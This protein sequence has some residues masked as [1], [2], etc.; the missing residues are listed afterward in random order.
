MPTADA[1]ERQTGLGVAMVVL[2]VLLSLIGSVMI[3]SA[4]SV[5]AWV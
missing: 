2:V 3:L 1:G 4:S 5:A